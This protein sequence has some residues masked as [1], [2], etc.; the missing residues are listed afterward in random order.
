MQQI[1][2]LRDSPRTSLAW[3]DIVTSFRLKLWDPERG[4]M[5]GYPSDASD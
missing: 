1:P 5:V 4:E 2:E 3:R